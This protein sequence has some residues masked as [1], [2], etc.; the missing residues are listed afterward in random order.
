MPQGPPTKLL[1]P[2]LGSLVLAAGLLCASPAAARVHVFELTVRFE[3]TSDWARFAWQDMQVRVL[4]RRLEVQGGGYVRSDGGYLAKAGYD[5][6]R[7][8]LSS[9]IRATITGPKPRLVLT[10]G[11]V[12]E[13]R[14]ELRAG[15][16][17]LLAKVH[18]GTVE[19]DEKNTHRIDLDATALLRLPSARLRHHD[20][21]ALAFYYGWYG[22]PRG[23]TGRWR[24]WNPGRK[25]HDSLNRP[26]GGWYD[27]LDPAVV[28]RHC[29]QARRAGLDGL[30]LSWWTS[31]TRNRRLLALWLPAA[32]KHGL[33]LTIYVET[34]PDPKALR[35]GLQQLMTGPAKDPAWLRADGKPVFFLYTRVLG[36][37]KRR[38]LLSATTGLGA[39][40]VGDTLDADRLDDFDALHTYYIA[41]KT[42]AYRG[43]LFTLRRAARLADKRLIAT[44][45][46]GYDDTNIRKPG[47]ARPR[48][49]AGFLHA[50]FA[51]A[52]G[53]DW[54]LL[55]SFNEWH[56]GSE[57]EPSVEHGARFLD[58][59][60]ASVRRWK[61][62]P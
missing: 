22:T 5:T 53:A 15:K 24:H 45:M 17:K 1:A 48:S 27:S 39:F 61:A 44:V 13:S 47:F 34:A 52:A 40:V 56:E 46:P 9:R 62:G 23:P 25:H 37:L 21:L 54:V 60:A 26:V 31:Q 29:R 57:I 49:G 20:R 16:R 32:R 38:Q 12:G 28:D 42:E 3:T 18:K 10:K 8:A 59:F 11:N 58:L 19:D 55:T 41:R 36:Q 33:K 7:V 6:A 43:A 30:I 50:G 2:L 51:A 14:F 35:E 4:D